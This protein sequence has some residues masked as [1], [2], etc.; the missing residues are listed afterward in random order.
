MGKAARIAIAVGGLILAILVLMTA[1]IVSTGSWAMVGL[2]VLLAP[3]AVRA[4][5]IPTPSRLAVLAATV[6]AIPIVIQFL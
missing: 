1:T 5:R 4:A 2:G 3:S 6:I